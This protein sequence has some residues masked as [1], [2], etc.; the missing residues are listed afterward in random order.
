MYRYTNVLSKY[1]KNVL[2]VMNITLI[3]LQSKLHKGAC[4]DY[5]AS[6]YSLTQG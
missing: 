4:K 1:V 2:K 6:A 5:N 3:L